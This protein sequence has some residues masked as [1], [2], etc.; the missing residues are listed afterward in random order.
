MGLGNTKADENTKLQ[1]YKNT[2][3]GS[4]MPRLDG[5]EMPSLEIPAKLMGFPGRQPAAYRSSW[6]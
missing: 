6:T 1:E 5:Q 3:L 2:E 4:F